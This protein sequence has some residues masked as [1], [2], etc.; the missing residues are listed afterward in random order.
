MYSGAEITS[1]MHRQAFSA[2]EIDWEYTVC[3]IL[4]EG[5]NRTS[6]IP[7]N[8]QY[9][10]TALTLT[11][12]EFRYTIVVIRPIQKAIPNKYQSI[13]DVNVA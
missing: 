9:P 11:F 7:Y 6:V 8:K 13:I 3:T 12:F 4:P 5:R 1:T 10:Y 2:S